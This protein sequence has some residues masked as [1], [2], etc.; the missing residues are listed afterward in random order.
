MKSIT[1]QRKLT[2]TNRWGCVIWLPATQQVT[3]RR[4]ITVNSVRKL[5]TGSWKDSKR[6][7]VG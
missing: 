7:Y 4:Y 1:A 5:S 6:A 3:F 2:S